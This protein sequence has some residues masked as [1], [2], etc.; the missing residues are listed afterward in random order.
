VVRGSESAVF[1]CSTPL[2]FSLYS[3]FIPFRGKM[4]QRD[5][6]LG[7]LATKIGPIYSQEARPANLLRGERE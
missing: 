5:G 3:L 6:L 1:Y 2:D 4:F 7:K